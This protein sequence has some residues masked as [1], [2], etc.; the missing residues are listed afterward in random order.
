MGKDKWLTYWCLFHD[1][2]V[3]VPPKPPQELPGKPVPVPD[4]PP[5]ALQH[6][7]TGS[8]ISTLLDAVGYLGPDQEGGPDPNGPL[9]PYIRDALVGLSVIQLAS[10]LSDAGQAQELQATAARMV[11]D[12]FDRIATAGEATTAS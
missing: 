4:P 10:R 11:R 12:Q 6:M 8:A 1:C 9:G 5:Y 2:N 7:T 3:H